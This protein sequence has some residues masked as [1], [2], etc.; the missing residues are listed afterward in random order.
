MPLCNCPVRPF[1]V[2]RENRWVGL[3]LNGEKPIRNVLQMGLIK[4]FVRGFSL[5][6]CEGPFV[7]RQKTV[8][9]LLF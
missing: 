3:W 1:P 9:F 2:S 7:F 6:C 8:L 5:Y 4:K